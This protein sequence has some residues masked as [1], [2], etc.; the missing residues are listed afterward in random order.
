M[1]GSH[2]SATGAPEHRKGEAVEQEAS[3]FVNSIASLA[4]SS[5]TGKHPQ[6]DPPSGEDSAQDSVPDP[7][8]IVHSALGAKQKADG[9]KHD[10]TKVPMEAAMWSKARPAMHG[11][12]SVADYYERFA[13]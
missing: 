6:N 9:H 10:K 2:D 5:A 3:N 4:L 13:K 11:I 7:T 1:L 12:Q 8:A